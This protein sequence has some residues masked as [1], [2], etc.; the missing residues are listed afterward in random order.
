MLKNIF[1]IVASC[2]AFSSN[3]FAFWGESSSTDKSGLN[4]E[5]GYD[6]NT[7]TTIS[8]KLSVAPAKSSSLE[9]TTIHLNTKDGDVTVILGPWWNWEK[10]GYKIDSESQV[11]VTGSKAVGKN[12]EIYIF[13]KSVESR[14]GGLIT[15]RTDSGA[16]LWSRN[17][18]AAG[19]RRGYNA[20][21]SS[22]ASQRGGAMMRNGGGRR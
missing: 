20:G 14:E 17:G 13:A 11:S 3:A 4:I 18:S 7:V 10:N 5:S 1:I 21:G 16:P 6:P 22:A 19:L 8:G 15:L 12:G 2:L 9:Q